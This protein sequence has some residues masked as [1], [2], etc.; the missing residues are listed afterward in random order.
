M[1]EME[2]M[3]GDA[4]PLG[5]ELKDYDTGDTIG[6]D[7]IEKIELVIGKINKTYPGDIYYDQS[8]KMFVC[9]LSQAETFTLQPGVQWVQVRPKTIGQM[10]E[11]WHDVGSVTV[12]RS[13]SKAVL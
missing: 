7:M 1:R 5:L 11:G 12:V 2:I 3:Q 6:E 4:F 13:E 8:Q 9:P 10:V